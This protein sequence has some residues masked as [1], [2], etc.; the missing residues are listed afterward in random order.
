MRVWFILL[1]S[2]IKYTYFIVQKVK[3]NKYLIIAQ[4]FFTL[5]CH[6]VTCFNLLSVV[7]LSTTNYTWL[8]LI[9]KARFIRCMSM[10][11]LHYKQNDLM[12]SADTSHSDSD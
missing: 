3:E 12:S 7:I 4:I 6:Q 8:V 11:G 10:P 1:F 9:S 2:K 5:N